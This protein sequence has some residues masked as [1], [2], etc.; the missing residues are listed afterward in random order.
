MVQPGMMG[1]L[2]PCAPGRPSLNGSSL[3]T[4]ENILA[5]AGGAF[6]HQSCA[7]SGGRSQI[8]Q[9]IVAGLNKTTR[10]S[11]AKGSSSLQEGGKG[12]RGQ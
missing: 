5:A 6:V 3:M 11:A 9:N 10:L 12:G 1:A 7:S 4:Y 2:K 8:G